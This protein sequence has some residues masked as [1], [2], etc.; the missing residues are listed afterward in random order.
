[1][2]K[3]IAKL[4][5]RNVPQYVLLYSG[6]VWGFIQMVDFMSE[7]FDWPVSLV[8]VLTIVGFSSIPSALIFYYYIAQP[9]SLKKQ[10]PFYIGNLIII[11]FLII[12]TS[13]FAW[14]VSDVKI[15]FS[16]E[17]SIAVLPFVN[18]SNDPEQE[19]FSDGL[20][21]ELL[22]LLS[23][24]PE[25]KVIGRT[26]SFSFKGKNEDLRIIGEKLGVANILEGSVRK[27]GNK[28][29]VTAQLIRTADGFHLWSEKYDRDLEG[30]FKLQDEIAQA[31]VNQLQLK[32]LAVP[33]SAASSTNIEVHNLIL[34][35]NYFNDKLDKVNM[36]KA[37]DLYF[38]ALAI[39]SLDAKVWVAIARNYSR[40]VWQNYIEQNDGSEKTRKAIEKA[41]ALDDNSAQSHMV[42]A[43]YKL[44]HSFDW[45]GAEAA[46]QKA[47]SLEPGNPDIFNGLGDIRSLVGRWKE[48]EQLYNKS[49]LLNP[50][51]PLYYMNLGN[52]QSYLG[53]S[54][55]AIK[56]FKKVLEIDPGF[57][58]AHLYLGINYLL[59]G[60]P[61]LALREMQKEN[62]E[63]FKKFGLALAFHALN[64]KKEA[65]ETLEEFTDKYQNNWSYLLAQI[66]A[67]RGEKEEAFT[68]LETAYNKK[69]NWLFWLK[70]DPLLKN[71]MSDPRYTNFLKKMNLPL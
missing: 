62:M 42:M 46:L 59:L 61:D 36:D 3:L 23:K 20:S 18:M 55:D 63:I 38:Q 37:L 22:T 25:L 7:K 5:E 54:D 15:D 65:D 64:R 49:I 17:Q 14:K 26:S 16:T 32:L 21:E 69:D 67:F 31:V 30:I 11:I 44:Y 47:L 52:C 33:K 39:D 10:A 28:I 68:W 2:Q 40:Q 19:Y 29:R 13:P 27:E 8:K 1:M 4:R 71:I 43:G 66:H 6:F 70:G 12:Y 24:I 41:I 45:Q 56:S 9:N 58:R 34:Q 51:K 53:R 57:Q 48:A 50:L 60:K 35:G